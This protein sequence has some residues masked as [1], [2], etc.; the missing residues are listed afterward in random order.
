MLTMDV[1]RLQGMAKA[2]K[3]KSRSVEADPYTSFLETELANSHRKQA[4][5]ERK[6]R[7]AQRM[8]DTRGKGRNTAGAQGHE[9]KM[10]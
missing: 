9:Q 3:G 6:L 10:G 4:A 5:A 1:K 2:M 8:G 7:Q